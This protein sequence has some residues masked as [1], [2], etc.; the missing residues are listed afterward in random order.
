MAYKNPI[1]GVYRIY[2]AATDK[3]YIGS[4]KFI[5][6]RWNRHKSALKQNYHENSH[7]QFDYNQN[8]LLEFE[9]L[10]QATENDLV[11]REHH[12][13]ALFPDDKLYNI[14][15]ISGLGNKTRPPHSAETRAKIGASGKGKTRSTESRAK[16]SAAQQGKIVS[17]ETRAKIVA[18][19]E[20]RRSRSKTTL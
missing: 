20:R 13:M 1:C 3:S 6:T 15:R 12:Y 11:I 16:M 8:H 19:W 7:L 17:D 2:C 18:S 4:S 14:E 9:I 10:E 5:Q